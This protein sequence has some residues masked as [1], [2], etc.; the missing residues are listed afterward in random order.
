MQ[1]DESHLTDHELL[2]AADGEPSTARSGHLTSCWACRARKQQIETTIV[3]FVQFHHDSL[4]PLVPPAAA[5]RAL[6][7]ARLA[8]LAAVPQPWWSW[9]RTDF[10]W[11]PAAA[12]LT[13]ALIATGAFHRSTNRS[14]DAAPSR[15]VVRTVPV[16]V[17]E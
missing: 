10:A 9:G 13:L 17:P 2:L 11:K 6:L 14:T 15:P 5:P 7:K 12:V 3:S 1:V 16:S 4:D 8:E